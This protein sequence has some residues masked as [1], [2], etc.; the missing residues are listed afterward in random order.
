MTYANG[1]FSTEN[2]Y[3]Y[4]VLCQDGEGSPLYIKF[5]HSDHIHDRMRAVGQG[6]P[7]PA[8]WFAFIRVPYHKKRPLEKQLHWQFRSRKVRGEWFKFDALRPEDKREFND[9]CREAFITAIGK[10]G[11]WTKVS[12]EALDAEAKRRQ[13]AYLQ[14]KRANFITAGDRKKASKKAWRELKSYGMTGPKYS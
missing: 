3:V 11:A 2:S 14:A 6:S 13:A 1:V 5:G 7:I 12:I 8:K 10:G 9:G 4:A